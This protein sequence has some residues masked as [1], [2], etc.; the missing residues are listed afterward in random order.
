VIDTPPETCAFVHRTGTICGEIA[1]HRV[2]DPG[3]KGS[4]A[5]TTV[6]RHEPRLKLDDSRPGDR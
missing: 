1:N 5:F 3:R 4:H 2:H 6:P